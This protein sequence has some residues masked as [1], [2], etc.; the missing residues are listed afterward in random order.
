MTYVDDLDWENVKGLLI[1]EYM[2]WVE[3]DEKQ[4]SDSALF[5]KRGKSF[6]RERFQP[7]GGNGCGCSAHVQN[8]TS[9]RN[10][11]VVIMKETI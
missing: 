10:L 1:E 11:P 4:E 8:L 6:H 7:Q 3:K 2:K 5:V 9:G